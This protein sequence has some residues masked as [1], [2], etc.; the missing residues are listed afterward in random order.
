MSRMLTEEVW[1]KQIFTKKK[2]TQKK[3]KIKKKQKVKTKK[4]KVRVVGV[5]GVCCGRC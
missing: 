2:E 1:E 4:E 3:N 5:T